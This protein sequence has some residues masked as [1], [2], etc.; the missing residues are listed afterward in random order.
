[1]LAFAT[2]RL[3][4]VIQSVASALASRQD[5]VPS[6]SDYEE[7]ELW[8]ELASCILGSA[9]SYE[10]ASTAVEYLKSSGLLRRPTKFCELDSFELKIASALVNGPDGTLGYRFPSLRARQIRQTL[11]AIYFRGSSL[12]RFLDSSNEPSAVRAELV[13]IAKGIGPKQASLFLRNIGFGEFAVLDRH[14]VRFMLMRGLIASEPKLQTL[15]QYEAIEAVILA[16][17]GEIGIRIRELDLAAWVV[18]RVA[19]HELLT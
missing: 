12:R 3:D 8:F 6:F 1:M 5:R 10:Q 15:T 2:E 18:A 16:Y 17:A 9:V 11:E 14:V 13:R 19:K 4:G 7:E